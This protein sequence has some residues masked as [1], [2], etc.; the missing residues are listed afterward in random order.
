[1]FLV[2]NVTSTMDCNFNYPNDMHQNHLWAY[3]AFFSSSSNWFYLELLLGIHRSYIVFFF[4]QSSTL[5]NIFF[6]IY[7][8][9]F[10]LVRKSVLNHS[11]GTIHLA[12]QHS[13]WKYCKTLILVS[14]TLWFQCKVEVIIFYHQSFIYYYFFLNTNFDYVTHDL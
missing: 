14:H 3:H 2:W 4:A 6:A 12:K 7:L 1:M 13:W 11:R 8:E 10:V 9:N 5:W